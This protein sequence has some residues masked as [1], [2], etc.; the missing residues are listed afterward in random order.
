MSELE[1]QGISDYEIWPCIMYPDVVFSINASHKMIV[2][3]AKEAGLD[4]VCIAEDDLMFT[5]DGA[6][7]YFLSQKPDFKEYDLYLAAT[8][9]PETPPRMICGFHL[10]CVSSR[11][12][13]KFLAC[14]DEK[15][16]D[17]E[18][19]S[20]GGNFVFCYPFPALQRSGFSANNKCVCNYNVVLQDKDIYK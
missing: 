12:Y 6:W 19:N 2:R 14:D 10:Y 4:E 5:A 17:T 20:I 11:F 16:I 8:Y 1:K 13:E 7:D 9:V 15:H 3:A 18:M